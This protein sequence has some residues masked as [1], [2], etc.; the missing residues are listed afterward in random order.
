[1]NILK[2][3]KAISSDC[4][5]NSMYKL[6]PESKKKDFLEFA[7]RFGMTEDKLNEVL[8]KEKKN[9]N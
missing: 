2:L 7:K 8:A 1:M 5:F 4:P 6:I 9:G 3:K